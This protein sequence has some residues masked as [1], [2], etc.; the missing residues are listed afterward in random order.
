MIFR[1]VSALF[2]DMF[3]MRFSD[4]CWVNFWTFGYNFPMFVRLCFRMFFSVCVFGGFGRPRGSKKGPQSVRGGPKGVPK[5]VQIQSKISSKSSLAPEPHFG[6][7]WDRFGVDFGTILGQFWD[8]FGGQNG[9]VTENNGKR[10]AKQQTN[11][12]VAHES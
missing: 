10:T 2:F 8:V 11:R 12:E 3:L 6:A 9:T 1:V 4:R 7:F 5:G